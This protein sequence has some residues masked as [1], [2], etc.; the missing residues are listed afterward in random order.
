MIKVHKCIPV[1]AMDGQAGIKE[2]IKAAA[3]EVQGLGAELHAE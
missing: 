1:R 3:V 2:A